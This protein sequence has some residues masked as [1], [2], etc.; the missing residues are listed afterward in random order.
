MDRSR[1]SVTAAVS[2]DT[3]TETPC[4]HYDFCSE[5]LVFRA[6]DSCLLRLQNNVN[7]MC[8][9]IRLPRDVFRTKKDELGGHLNECR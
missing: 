3:I 6:C 1:H 9:E 5:R 4:R 7:C 2:L 8:F